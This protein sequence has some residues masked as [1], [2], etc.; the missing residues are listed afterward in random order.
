MLKKG[1]G[2]HAAAAQI[3]ILV[4]LD[5]GNE[6]GMHDLTKPAEVD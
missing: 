6:S 2:A 3:G 4:T 1:R 5:V